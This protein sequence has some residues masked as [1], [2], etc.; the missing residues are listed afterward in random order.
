MIRSITVSI[1]FILLCVTA[2]S[3]NNDGI[4]ISKTAG[5]YDVQYNLPEY[6]SSIMTREGEQYIVL[7]INNYGITPAEGLPMLPQ[8]SFNL[9]LSSSESYSPGFDISRQ[10]KEEKYLFNKIFPTQAP[11]EKSKDL[12][13]RPF[14]INRD[15]YATTG[16]IN[17]PLV[18][19]SEPFIIAGVKAVTVSITPFNYDPKSGRLAV[20]RSARFKI[21][22]SAGLPYYNRVP[23]SFRELFSSMFINFESLRFTPTNNYLIITPPEYET[24][25]APFASYKTAMG[26]NVL[27]VNTSV[28][29]TTN[30]A[31]LNYIQNRYNNLATRPEF[32]LLVGDVD[33]IPEWVGIGTPDNPHTD[34]NYT[35]LEGSDAYADAFIGRFPVASPT[36]IT[37]MINKIIFM[38]GSIG[39]LPKKNIF[40]AS[41]DNYAITEGTHNF[42][43]DSFFAPANYTNIKLYTHTYGATTQ[44]L[45]DALNANQVFAIYSGHGSETSWADGPPLNQS[46]VNAL[47]NTYFPF[48]YS[49]ACLT[50]QLQYA[51]CFGETWVRGPKGGSV[52]WGSSVTSYWDEDDI[53]ERRL[54]RAMFT[55][56]L[57]R[58][59]PMF[60]AGK[61]Y[62]VQYYGSVTPTMRRYLE[63]YNCFGDP[64]MYQAAFGPVIAHTQLPNTENL[65][66]PYAVNCIITPAGSNIDASKTKIFWTRGTIFSDSVQMTNTN[67][68]NWTANIPGNGSPA[69]YRYYIKTCDMAGRV[70]VLPPDAPSGYFSF[71]AAPDLTPPM[72]SHSQITNIGQ[73]MWPVTVNAAVSDNLGIDS[74]WVDWYINTPAIMKHFRL[75]NTS[76]INYSA[77]FNSLNSDVAV[78]DSVFYVIKA[79]DN[80]SNHNT[81]QLP[82]AGYF[83]IG[84]TAQA[85]TSFC[86]QTYLP[87]RDNQ[88]GYDTLYVP[89]FGQ[90]VD[91]NFKMESLTHTWDGDVTFTIKSPS[92]QEVTLSQ[93]RG[94]SGDNFI[95]TIFD[96]S[97]ATPIANGTAPFTGTFKP[98]A[99]LN[100]FNGQEVHGNWILKV[101]DNASG[102]T[103]RVN[104][105]CLNV[106]YNGIIGITNNQ[107]PVKFSLSQNYPNPFNPVT[108]ITYSVPKQT[109]VTIKVYDIIGREVTTL[110]NGVKTAGYYDIEWNA[111]NYSSG[112]Y[113]YRMN[114]GEFVDVKKMIVIK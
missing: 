2:Y 51:E 17:S 67:G 70:S 53:L 78:G 7:N 98:E 5:G 56:G 40:M 57:K 42:V 87:I 14:T 113:F 33:K 62:L 45:I 109:F 112:V 88:T 9:I 75:P 16:S 36:H 100:V 60:V 74:V 111:M 96:D 43:I 81:S 61:Y 46:H 19:I 44:Q 92:G 55:D 29:G 64:S 49:F 26:Y 10:S 58:S 103:G 91:L 63:M 108:K 79:K 69:V 110:I 22:L 11:W 13:D 114:A 90:I 65:S 71:N 47:T 73:P 99:V 25:M 105:Y 83:K 106:I 18:V 23:E 59:A 86:K 27:M 89:Q 72:I 107:I 35:L 39:G 21:N 24:P 15:Y 66:G 68:N 102:D 41:N 32:I 50:G 101:V 20:T 12:K 54:Y 95:N 48:V 28:T 85:F 97:A 4:T 82:L 38:E 8:I 1:V 84:I 37:N 31:I 77:M 34:L 104:S 30:T 6:N 52:Y 93:N 94:S 3:L 80:S 76:G